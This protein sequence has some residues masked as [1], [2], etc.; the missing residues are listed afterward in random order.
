MT[1]L[2]DWD[3][4]RDVRPGMLFRIDEARFLRVRARRGPR[5]SPDE[6]DPDDVLALCRALGA[7][8]RVRLDG[9]DPATR[10]WLQARRG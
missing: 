6:P 5:A 2:P 8:S 4:G 10:G 9:A 7:G 3:W 1:D